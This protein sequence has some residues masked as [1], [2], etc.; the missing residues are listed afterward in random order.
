MLQ[1]FM[2]QLYFAKLYNIIQN[3]SK[4]DLFETSLC[5]FCLIDKSL[6]NFSAII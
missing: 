6:Q 4:D 1:N 5:R 3:A 2:I